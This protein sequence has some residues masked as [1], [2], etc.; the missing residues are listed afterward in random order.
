LSRVTGLKDLT[1]EI[2][3]RE[4]KILALFLGASIIQSYFMCS[5]CHSFGSYFR[6][7]SFTFF[8]WVFLWRGNNSLTHF[9]SARISWIEYPLKRFIVGLITTIAYTFA[10]TFTLIFIFQT[11][12]GFNFGG[13]LRFTVITTVILTVVISLFLHSREFLLH[14]RKATLD[15]ERFQRERISAKYESLK[16]K[17]NPQLL[18]NSLQSLGGLIHTD[19]EH[20][21][22]FIKSLSDVY[23]YILDT[24]DKE[25]VTIESEVKFLKAFSFLMETRYGASLR[26]ENQLDASQHFYVSPLSVH[27]II[28]SILEN[29]KFDHTTPLIITIGAKKGVIHVAAAVRWNSGESIDNVFE[30]LR[31]VEDRY[32]FLSESAIEYSIAENS[33]SC[34]FPA[35]AGEAMSPIQNQKSDG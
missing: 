33:F 29:A 4:L 20:A 7:I 8:M 3:F 12:F 11:F 34:H 31:D 15:A 25:V 14:W 27:L 10:V 23:R 18:Y 6:V 28:E 1:K 2:I 26:I 19:K 21:V 32:S 9:V 16:N 22:K 24:R 5:R 13:S 17:V 35:I 30:L